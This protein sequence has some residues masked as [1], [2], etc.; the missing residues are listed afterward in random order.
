MGLLSQQLSRV[1]GIRLDLPIRIHV[2]GD[3]DA[4][5]GSGDDRHSLHTVDLRRTEASNELMDGLLAVLQEVA[6]DRF[7]RGLSRLGGSHVLL[8]SSRAFKK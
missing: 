7:A 4:G 2:R 1:D 8:L 5:L 3:D 6:L